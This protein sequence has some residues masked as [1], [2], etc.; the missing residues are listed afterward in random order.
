MRACVRS[1][2]RACVFVCVRVCVC[3][4]VCACVNLSLTLYLHLL[5]QSSSRPPFF[6]FSHSLAV[7]V[8]HPLSHSIFCLVSSLSPFTPICLSPSSFLS[9]FIPPFYKLMLNYVAE[10]ST[11]DTPKTSSKRDEALRT[12]GEGSV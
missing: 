12:V 10:I 6:P 9:A 11:T 5:P 1:C 3:M 2:A 7:F 4:C 8:L